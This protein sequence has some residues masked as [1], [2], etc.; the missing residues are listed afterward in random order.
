MRVVIFKV[1]KKPYGIYQVRDMSTL[2]FL[3]LEKECE[4]NMGDLLADYEKVKS[5]LHDAFNEI[6]QLKQE[7]KYLKGE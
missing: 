2:E 6:E 4:A 3:K 5:D 1:G 7:I